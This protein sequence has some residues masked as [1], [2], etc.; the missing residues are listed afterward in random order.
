MSTPLQLRISNALRSEYALFEDA[1]T[2][3][4]FEGLLVLYIADIVEGKEVEPEGGTMEVVK[5]FAEWLDANP[6]LK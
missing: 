2:P 4:E 6:S 5:A 1:F 3:T